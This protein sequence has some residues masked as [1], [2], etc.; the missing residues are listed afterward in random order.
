V[1]F[2][3]DSVCESDTGRVKKLAKIILKIM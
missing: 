3:V 2:V 1:A